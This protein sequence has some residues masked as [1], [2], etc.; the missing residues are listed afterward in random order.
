MF[1]LKGL[2]SRVKLNN[3]VEMPVFGF[4]TWQLKEGDE[5]KNAVKFAIEQGYRLIDTASGYFNEKS[6]GLAIKESNVHREELFIATKVANYDQGYDLTLRAFD[7][8]MKKLDLKYLDLYL[9]HWPGKNKFIDTW[10]AME[11]LYEEGRIKAIGVC[12]FLPHHL[13]RLMDNCKVVPVVNQVECHPLLNQEE[14]R[15]YCVERN[16][17]LEAYCPLIRGQLDWPVLNQLAEKYGKTNAQIILRWHLQRDI[18]PIPKS[19]NPQRIVENAQVFDFELSDDDMEAINNM[20]EEKR[21]CG[22]PDHFF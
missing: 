9:I 10:R 22:H 17:Q 19:A 11:K 18:I 20:N 6:V 14:L 8:S 12:N 2:D 4:G 7:E 5:A 15:Q 3:G 16:I 1:E 13:E 21:I